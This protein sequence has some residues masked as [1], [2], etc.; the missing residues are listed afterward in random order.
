[1]IRGS[2]TSKILCSAALI[3]LVVFFP[4][5]TASVDSREQSSYTL[6]RAT[7]TAG[8]ASASGGEYSL[9]ETLGQPT[10][11][12]IGASGEKTLYAGIYDGN[13]IPT[14]TGDMPRA[15]VHVLHQNYPNPFNPSTTISYTVGKSGHVTVEI[16]SVDGRRI[17]VLVDEAQEP[18]DRSVIWDGRNDKEMRVATG[19]YFCRLEIDSFST[20]RKMLLIQ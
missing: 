15:A 2:A 6:K 7:F 19:I 3:A 4:V 11:I 20:V 5:T 10:P 16:Y 18:G 1:M 13:V 14:S 8:G 17:R 12:G 9:S